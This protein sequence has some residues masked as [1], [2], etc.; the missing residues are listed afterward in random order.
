MG[1]KSDAL[2]CI[3]AS[4]RVIV[5]LPEIGQE[6]QAVSYCIDPKKKGSTVIQRYLTNSGGAVCSGRDI[7]T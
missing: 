5:K 6:G 2:G 7:L 1:A 4:F 3:L